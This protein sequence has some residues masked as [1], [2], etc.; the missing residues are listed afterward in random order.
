MKYSQYIIVFFLLFANS[1][2]AYGNDFIESCFVS[3]TD[4]ELVAGWFEWKPYQYQVN[5]G[6]TK[7]VTGLDVELINAIAQ[8]I[9]VKIENNEVSWGKHLKDLSLGKRDIAPAATYTKDR[10]KFAYFTKP[11][12]YEENALFVSR[13]YNKFLNFQN[14]PEFLVQIKA[15]NFKLGVLNGAVYADENINNF[16]DDEN[17]ADLIVKHNDELDNLRDLIRGEI[18]GFITDRLVGT[19]MII[20]NKVGNFV[21][22][23]PLHI[24][25]PISFM[26]SK[27]TITTEM[28]DDFNQAIDN[29]RE[30]GTHSEILRKYLFHILLLQTKNSSWFYFITIIGVISFALS[31]VLISAK[32]NNNLLG[33]YLLA[34]IPS[35]STGIIMDIASSEEK[36]LMNNTSLYFIIIFSVSIFGFAALR[37]LKAFNKET[38]KDLLM[39]KFIDNTI[40]YTDALGQACFI[41]TGV[42]FALIFQ[43]N[44]IEF[45]GL[46]IAFIL[47]N[48]GTIIRDLLTKYNNDI[49]VLR[50]SVNAEVTIFWALIFSIYFEYNAITLPSNFA[51][52]A[53][54]ITITLGAFITRAFFIRYKIRNIRYY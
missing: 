23:I 32:E 25:T 21:E 12:R 26:L 46:V 49:S 40:L 20:D 47:A 51:N 3:E 53:V 14:I 6:Y 36:L 39:K 4:T 5:K 29:I 52:S 15:L 19:S 30:N 42:A 37:L 38:N 17:N 7:E 35:V 13:N 24:K 50:D 45:W 1:I 28:L 2:K 11:Y 33:T 22:E 34:I 9:G 31:G 27:Q 41:V 18:D 54:A 8:N 43:L 10:E 16:I 48:A 44:P